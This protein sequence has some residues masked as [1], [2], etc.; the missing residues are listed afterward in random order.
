MEE[1]PVLW[2]EKTGKQLKM[3]LC[4]RFNKTKVWVMIE[5]DQ[6]QAVINR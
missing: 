5:W 3:A 6:K 2:P 4:K 1:R